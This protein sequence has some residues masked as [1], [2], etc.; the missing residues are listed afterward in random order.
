MMISSRKIAMACGTRVGLLRAGAG[1]PLLLLH[2]IG[3]DAE[4]FRHQLTGL[5]DVFTVLAWD[6]P[7]YGASDEP[8]NGWTLADYADRVAGLLDALGIERVALLGQSWGGVIAQEVYRRHAARVRALILADT[9]PGGG[10]Q[11]EDERQASLQAR[12]TALATQTPQEL[13]HARTPALLG[14]NATPETAREVEAMMARI[15]PTGYRQAAIVLA[16]A[17]GRDVLP[18]V[19]VPTLILAG[20]HDRV[21][22]RAQAEY[23]RDTI[24]GARLVTFNAGHL[25]AQ[26]QPAAFNA[27]LREFLLDLGE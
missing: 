1:P 2:G 21:V 17:D 3:G 8:G 7:G 15:R 20:E 11:P 26:E 4:Q 9:Y 23:L 12:L 6:A 10:S 18:A 27:A 14:P 24:L 16:A 5:A 19:A 22:P 25:P 13:A